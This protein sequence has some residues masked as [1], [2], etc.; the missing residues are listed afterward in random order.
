MYINL[1]NTSLKAYHM[2]NF[3]TYKLNTNAIKINLRN[4][5]LLERSYF[6]DLCNR[7]YDHEDF[8]NYPY[9]SRR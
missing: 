6:C 9:D 1:F 3:C 4:K 5:S 7:G 8:R 2:I